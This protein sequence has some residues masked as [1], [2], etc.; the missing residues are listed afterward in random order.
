MFQ[1]ALVIKPATISINIRKKGDAITLL[2]NFFFLFLYKAIRLQ[3]NI[4]ISILPFMLFHQNT[5]KVM[6]IFLVI[7]G[8]LVIVSMIA[9]YFPAFQ[10]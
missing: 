8:V 3:G 10:Y 2:V 4:S 7:V 1:E 5:K 6:R 9:F